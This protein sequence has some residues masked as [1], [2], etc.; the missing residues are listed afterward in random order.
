MKPRKIILPSDAFAAY[1]RAFRI[2]TPREIEELLREM[3]NVQVAVVKSK[4]DAEKELGMRKR[5][6]TVSVPLTVFL[7]KIRDGKTIYRL[8]LSARERD[9]LVEVE[10]I[11]PN[12]TYV[13]LAEE[14][15]YSPELGLTFEGSG[16]E[17]GFE[18][19]PNAE[20]YEK[21]E[22]GCFQPWEKHAKGAWNRSER[23]MNIYRPF[24]EKWAE[25]IGLK[26]MQKSI[27][28]S[29]SW[30]IRIAVLF[31]DVGKLN[32]Q[33]QEIAWENERKISGK[34]REGY[35]ARTSSKKEEL[36]ESLKKELKDLPPHAPFAYPFIRTFLRE[37]LGDYRF[38]DTIALAAARHHSLEVTGAIKGE[39]EWDEWNG[40]RADEWLQDQICKLLNL[41]GNDEE[42]MRE[43]IKEA[44]KKVREKS[45]A[46]EPPGPTDDFYFLYC[47][48][49]RIVKICDWEDAGGEEIELR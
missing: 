45:R 48:T 10:M 1:E 43:A 19:Q 21:A 20:I 7:S 3:I 31:H 5:L 35:I 9:F 11:R 18:P 15:G 27:A 16:H 42:E 24:I 40:K 46:D 25:N 33:W 8:D 32:R 6:K 44:S 13:L 12:S 2:G 28:D 30:A 41:S 4:E 39:F 37:V 26:A 49:N 17:T 22:S 47:I 36:K 38:L 23:I 34:P 14:A 29:L